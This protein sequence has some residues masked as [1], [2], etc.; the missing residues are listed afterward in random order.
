VQLTYNGTVIHNFKGTSS[1]IWDLMGS[2]VPSNFNNSKLDISGGV[3][4][5]EPI[6]TNWVNLPMS[7]VF[8]QLSGS[9]LM[10][11]G[12]KIE[13]AVVNLNLRMAVPKSTYVARFVYSYNSILFVS[14]GSAEYIY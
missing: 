2:D 12:L 7:Q 13:N 5:S 11:G 4:T 9:H 14:G 8:E 1:Q 6:R 3:F 10:V